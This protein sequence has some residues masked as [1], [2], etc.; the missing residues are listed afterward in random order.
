MEVPPADTTFGELAAQNL[1]ITNVGGVVTLGL[2]CPGDPGDNTVVRASA[3]QSQG[4]SVCNDLRILGTV[5]APVEGKADITALY[6]AKFGVPGVGTKIFVRCNR[7]VNGI[8][9]LGR[10]FWAIVPAGA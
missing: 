8:E 6:S 7:M 10:E 2:T 3:P 4:R 9:D 5:P 1:L